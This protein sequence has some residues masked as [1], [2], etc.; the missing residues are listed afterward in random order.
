[1]V[2]RSIQER[3][4]VALNSFNNGDLL[5]TDNILT[6]IVDESED[7]NSVYFLAVVKSQLGEF[8]DAVRLYERVVSK[9]PNHPE[10]YFNMALCYQKM[11]DEDSALENYLKAIE[12]NPNLDD[13]YN[14]IAFIYQNRGDL[15]AAEKYLMMSSGNQAAYLANESGI[16]EIGESHLIPEISEAINLIK[17]GKI[18][19]AKERL[20]NSLPNYLDNKE[21][22]SALGNVSFHSGDY[23][24]ALNY[25]QKALDIAKEDAVLFY[26]IA[27]CLQRLEKKDEAF[28]Y[29]KKSIELKPDFADA[30]NNIALIYFN[31]KDY[32]TAEEYFSRALQADPEHL[33]SLV[34]L[35]STKTFLNDYEA[36][37]AT[38]DLALNIA[39]KKNDQEN[40][41]IIYTNIGFLELRKNNLELAL[42]F[43]DKSLDYNPDYVIANYNKG[44]TLL[45]LGHFQ[46]GWKFYEKR[47]YREEFGPRKFYKPLNTLD[48]LKGKRIL[49]YAEQG[50]G[51]A[52]HFLRYLILL[53][54]EGAYIIFECD[55]GLHP[56]LEKL[57]YI[58]ELLER[59]STEK[60]DI[61]YDYDIPLLSLANLYKTDLSN[62]PLEIP[63]IKADEEKVKFW[64][65]H[66]GNEGFKI[67]IVWGGSPVH[68]N[69]KNRS[70][71]LSQLSFLFN[72]PN[73]KF[74][75]LQKGIPQLQLS[76]YALMVKDMD[77]IGIHSW[78]DTA[79]IIE[80]L[81]LVISVDTSVCHLA[82]AMGKEVWVLLPYNSDWRWLLN[83]S[84]SPWYPNMKLYRQKSLGDWK[85]VFDKLEADLKEKIN[86]VNVISDSN[87]EE[88]KTEKEITIQ[89]DNLTNQPN[90]EIYELE[91]SQ[92]L[93]DEI[94]KS[95]YEQIIT[96]LELPANPMVA[97]IGGFDSG[98]VNKFKQLTNKISVYS[99]N[100]NEHQHYSDANIACI[101][102]TR[103]NFKADTKFDFIWSRY[104]LNQSQSPASTIRALNASLNENGFAYIEI[105]AD[106]TEAEHENTKGNNAIMGIKMWQALFSKNGFEIITA[107]SID[108]TLDSGINDKNYYFLL[109]KSEDKKE[110][111]N[112][113]IS[114]LT[115][116]LPKGENF[117]WGVCSKY[118]RQELKNKVKIYDANADNSVPKKIEGKVFHA[119]QNQNFEPMTDI[120]GDENYG[121][122]FFEFEL[123]NTSVE[124]AKKFN[125]VIAGSTWCES[126]MHEKGIQN[127]GVLIQGIDPKR[128]YPGKKEKNHNLFVIFSGGKFELR[129]G[130][131]LVLKA[132]QIL[133][134]KYDD[135]ILVNA[136]YN[137]W[138]HSM[139]MMK[140]SPYIKYEMEGETWKNK[141]INLCKANDIDG[142]RVFTLPVVPNEKLR[143]VY[144]NTDIGLFPNRCEGGTN[145][146][147]M[148]YMA[149]GKPVIASYNTGHKD[150]L[151]ESNSI[152]LTE[153]KEFRINDEQGSLIADWQ[154]PSLDEIIA[155]IEW[156]YQNRDK[157]SSIGSQAAKD[158]QNFT[159]QKTA[160]NLI[161]LVY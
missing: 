18:K 127:T 55:K 109:R 17:L 21:Y 128:F 8:S 87:P 20:V 10:A 59:I 131:D 93:N 161:K 60:R 145:L 85:E 80:N 83:R 38:F 155:K 47:I 138:P 118:I 102:T 67:G 96:Q 158:M 68:Q 143:E 24:D 139:E 27:V 122:T 46:E 16:G 61:E 95:I 106:N 105:P 152:M 125:K 133:Q 7:L 101:K 50:L 124:N 72:I 135:M 147:L 81:D 43:F 71:K 157:L 65:E 63:Y 94:A 77:Q 51:D 54:R 76:D 74:F 90:S 91:V 44:E 4:N 159:W 14:N 64:K 41:S 154:E 82:G 35:G 11:D 146:V 99:T 78:A 2:L 111:G 37:S 130:Q 32:L 100:K 57:D 45:K 121:Y 112:K 36:A 126:K 153:M 88:I 117:G 73:A 120:W 75:S 42:E 156:A 49:V 39:N 149:C 40:L 62:I 84:D 53:K 29:Y 34:N 5:T 69:D 103:E 31:R 150:I 119:L 104:C 30:L 110:E 114:T 137:L 9:M 98:I 142:D 134:Q 97:I 28:T 79:A 48:N 66:V 129:K 23:E 108:I 13:A 160:E 33:N 113:N 6:E 107:D 141:M 89:E 1:M 19:K 22:L 116:S 86:A 140:I 70:V 52:L 58:D 12:I 136:W 148:E 151:T 3:Y 115:L 56:L 26:S 25:F 123:N 132:F 144:L 15:E 92:K